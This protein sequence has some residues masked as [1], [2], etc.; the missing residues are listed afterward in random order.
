MLNVS[1]FD[2]AERQREKSRVRE[3]DDSALRNGQISR[4]ELQSENGFFASL[5]IVNSVIELQ[6]QPA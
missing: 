5:K 2:P 4:A 1:H 3:A 6:G